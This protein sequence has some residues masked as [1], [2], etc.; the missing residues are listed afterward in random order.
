MTRR[1]FRRSI[2]IGAASCAFILSGA[3]NAQEATTADPD[4]E[5]VVQI[6]DTSDSEPE[7]RQDKIVVTGSLLARDEFASSSPIQVI[8]AEVATLEGL[9][10][11]A[12]ILQGSS[13][14]S[15]STQL[16]NTFQNFVT[17]GGIGAQT[18]DLRG[19]GDTRTLVLIDGKRPGP[20]GTRG[21][22]AALDL[23]V[24]PQSIISRIEILK[25]GASTIYGSDA[26]CGVVN[27][28]T[29]DSVDGF[30]LNAQA[31]QPFES[32]GEQYNISGAYGFN[33]GDNAEFT[34]SAEYRLNEQL[35]ISQ[36]DY[37]DCTRDYVSKP[38]GGGLID[39]LNFSATA[40]D[41]T[42]NCSNL[43][44]NTV[45]DIFGGGGRLVPSPE[46]T[47]IPTVYGT[48]VPGYRPRVGTGFTADGQPFYE[49]ILDAAFLDNQDFIPKN[50]NISLFAS[51]DIEIAGM[52][53]D[54]EALFSRR[55]TDV[56]GWRQFFPII[57]SSVNIAGNDPFYSYI[58][59]PSYVSPANNIAQVVLPYP[60]QNNVEVDYTYL[61]TSLSGGF[62]T[63]ML[64]G[65]SWKL[66][67]TYS[68]GEGKYGG[69]EILA[70]KSSDWN[71]DGVGDFN[72]DG[73][74]D[75]VSSPT[76]NF[77]DP[78]VL[79]G[80]RSDELVAAIGGYQTGKTTYD[81]TTFTA[82]VAG[83]VF[84]L[85]AGPLGLG[86]GAEYREFSIDDQPG[87]L[88]RTG[89]IWGS[90][91]AG[92]TVGSNNV[93]EVFAEINV[94]IFKGAPFAEDV[95]VSGSV[96]AFDY[97]LG[98]SDSIYKAG[99]N[100]QINPL[101]RVRSSYGTSYR[102]PALFELFLQDETAFLGQLAID[103]CID[104]GNSNN[105]NIRTN[106]AADGIPADYA[107]GAGSAL[108]T[109]SGG[110]A[111]L[112]PETGDTFTAG[113]IFTP[114]F[115]DLNIALDYYEIEINDQIAAIGAGQI[116][117]GC[118]GTNTFP[119]DFC[120]LLVRNPAGDLSEFSIDSVSAPILNVDSQ[121]QRGLDLEVRY[122]NEFD[123]GTL[124]VEGSINWALERY[125][126][127]FGSDFV[128]GVTDNDFNGTIG[129][130]SVV[131]DVT[132]RLDRGDWT[133][134][135]F[136]DFIGRQDNNRFDTD[137][138]YN[139][140]QDY[141]GLSGIYKVYTEAAFIH[142]LSAR[143]SGDTWTITGG[144][145]NIFDEGVPQVSDIAGI[146]QLSAGNSPVA[147]TGY[148]VRGRR[149]FV[150]VSKTF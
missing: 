136:T 130:P 135:W 6:T 33:I 20:S 5:V 10:D 138:D 7:A 1:P 88:S 42:R 4:D 110:G 45:L 125:I 85:P 150:S 98:G 82:V 89:D 15:G 28:I 35:D 111:A 131:G 105:Q 120:D 36:R 128:S 46:G 137:L 114:T 18:I 47:T 103:P 122:T 76:F 93:T 100:W 9:V 64:D 72:G 140:P 31:T 29:R 91:T 101:L 54:S 73:I 71:L 49:D 22:I 99:I 12:S 148:D 17:N 38:G 95:E 21:S 77:F 143:W 62:G 134:S 80:N 94:P 96:R 68:L 117:G 70:S 57:G 146:T 79:A 2:L 52:S 55:T 147:A 67:A 48:T 61:S 14:A 19:C 43:Y 142:G 3:V 149:A 107:G 108:I 53:W 59:D 69:T 112:Q 39:R 113:I 25:D 119:N 104:W 40:T 116:V 121:S 41:P 13:L 65:W 126:N 56:E 24:V 78:D 34:I 16:N 84:E 30:E 115:S 63:T 66:D 132:F 145:Q 44:H 51:A 23:N 144:V 58:D 8:T 81:Q 83:E 141:F 27:I 50:E 139:E 90:S 124:T 127:V 106:C 37:L 60:T 97:E 74:P 11:T 75:T 109:T 26:V 86:L 32:G 92:P 129:Y 123:F 118:Y 133:Y 87:E 102:A